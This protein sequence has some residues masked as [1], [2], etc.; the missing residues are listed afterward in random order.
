[1]GRLISPRRR[2]TI[3]GLIAGVAVLA[4]CRGRNAVNSDQ[5]Y[6]REVADAIPTIERGTGL[7]FKRAPVLRT[8]TH[9]QVRAF[10]EQRFK[11]EV[12]DQQIAGEQIFYRRLGLIPDTL[13]LRRFLIDLLTEQVIGFYDPHTKVLYVV[14]SAPKDEVGF[15][16]SHEL[17][18]ALQDQ[19]MNLDS[20]QN[21][22]GESDRMLAAQ[23]V[24]EGQATLVPLMAAFGAGAELP[25]GWDRVRD[26][27]RNSH[28]S[29]M[30]VFRSAPM[31]L[32]ETLI[33]PYLS[34]AEFMRQFE[35]RRPG[36]QPYGSNMPT[37]TEQILHPSTYF[38]AKA[39]QPLAIA[40]PAPRSGKVMY[41]D[42]M[43]EFGTR[44][45]L[46]Q[47]LQ[48]QNAAIRVAAGWAGDRYEVVHFPSGDGIAWLTF[49]QSAVQ[50]AEYG[51]N[52]EQVIGRRFDQPT[53]RETKAGKA[54]E[55]NGRSITLWG[56]T[57]AG[58]PAVLYTDLPAGISSSVIEVSKVDVR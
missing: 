35:T 26:M 23:A 27:I 20:I 48:D 36:Q 41:E 28:S 54:Y 21:V 16:I 14:D 2:L 33:F 31:M 34:G 42:D 46:F 25:G 55:V 9:D 47:F 7:K 51:S 17:V 24:I 57:V 15:V 3:C 58:R 29:D 56:G 4:G 8:Q 1:M 50:A 44:L 40:F 13:D 12:T 43:G 5:P 49:W 19:Y 38:A 30:A 53:A 52:V 32:Q 37:S 39:A 6:A 11:D 22:R 45:F 10:L 18:H